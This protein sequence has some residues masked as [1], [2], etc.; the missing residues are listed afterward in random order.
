MKRLIF[1]IGFLSLALIS[2]ISANDRTAEIMLDL[3]I[4][5]A[6][7]AKPD[8]KNGKEQYRNCAVCHSPEGWG[9]ISGHY[10]QIAG[11]HKSVIIK[12]LEDIHKGNRDNPTMYPFTRPLF[13]S[14]AQA[15]AD[16][17]A[18]INQLPMNPKNTVGY[19]SDLAEGKKI[20][21]EH[22]EKCHGNNG[23]GD[24]DKFYPQIQGQH[25]GYLR[26]QII[27]LKTGKRRNGDQKMLKQ[28][29][30]LSYRQID[31]VAD[32]ISRMTPEKEKLAKDVNWKNPDFRDTF[33][34]APR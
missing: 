18:Y 11:Q 22:C 8:L 15:V 10:P 7:E 16:V 33:Q 6:I 19:G 26:R 31:A 34:S 20:Y 30:D 4:K 9:S 29:Q 21:D 27:W 23:Q 17:S 2:I 1:K 25:F 3:V 24:A 32:Y 12:Q 14:G 28:I 13:Q 5:E